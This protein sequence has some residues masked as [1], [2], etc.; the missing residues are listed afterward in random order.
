MVGYRLT[1]KFDMKSYCERF[2]RKIDENLE[3]I[4]KSQ[5]KRRVKRKKFDKKI[6]NYQEHAETIADPLVYMTKNPT[7]EKQV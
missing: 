5:R 2:G 6:H 7:S 4:F 1:R 3:E